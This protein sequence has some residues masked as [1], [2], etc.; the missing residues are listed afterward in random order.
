MLDTLL[1]LFNPTLCPETESTTPQDLAD[2]KNAFAGLRLPGRV[3]WFVSE[4][5]SHYSGC[6]P[7]GIYIVIDPPCTLRLPRL[8]LDRNRGGVRLMTD[9]EGEEPAVCRFP[10]LAAALS[11]LRRELGARVANVEAYKQSV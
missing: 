4:I 7:S 2:V 6:E 8:R 11:T 9:E 3:R 10:T 1:H 5:A